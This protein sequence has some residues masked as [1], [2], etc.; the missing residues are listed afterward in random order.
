MLAC[1]GPS[2]CEKGFHKP[3]KS[4]PRHLTRQTF[5]NEKRQGFGGI[6]DKGASFRR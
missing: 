4:G 5:F 1:V 6:V 3:E 2:L